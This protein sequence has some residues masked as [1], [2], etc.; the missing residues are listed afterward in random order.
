MSRRASGATAPRRRDASIEAATTTGEHPSRS[1]S[2]PPIDAPV[3]LASPERELEVA[4][5]LRDPSELEILE[6]PD[7]VGQRG[8]LDGPC[9]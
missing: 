4:A 9:E 7:P 3:R 8:D 1:R 2:G 5:V 6:A